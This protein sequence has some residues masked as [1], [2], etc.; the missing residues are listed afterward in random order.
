M[1]V[2]KRLAL[3]AV[4]SRVRVPENPITRY[5]ELSHLKRLLEALNINCMF[6]VGANR[7]QFATELRKIGYR[8]HII[9]FEPVE[10]EFLAL[11]NAFRNDRKWRGYQCA[12]GSENKI[13]EIN[14]F[15][16]LTVL[17]SMLAPIGKQKNVEVEQVEVKRL[18]GLFTKAL[19]GIPEPRVF[20][21]M[22]TQGFD[23][24]VFRG[25]GM[26]ANEVLG[27]QS[28]ISVKPIYEGMP[29]YLDV[30]SVY[31]QAGFTLFDLTVVA[32]TEGGDLQELNCFMRR[33]RS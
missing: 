28:E 21:K 9:S 32:R 10:R 11:R 23:L 33:E 25:A 14:V 26:H 30:L 18:D 15:R 6:D 27:L 16:D 12:L 4:A 13:A 17:S 20:L 1:Q 5:L 3:S 29:H 22:D 19:A 8:G 7:G 24:E 2:I 31:E